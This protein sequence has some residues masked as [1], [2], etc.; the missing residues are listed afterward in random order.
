MAVSK[1][2][3]KKLSEYTIAD[4]KDFFYELKEIS[5]KVILI[6]I[7]NEFFNIALAK[8]KNG[9]LLIKKYIGNLYQK[10]Q[11]KNLCQQIHRLDLLFWVFKRVKIKPTEVAISIPS[12]ACYTR[13]IEIPD[14]VDKKDSIEF[15]ENQTLGY[16]YLSH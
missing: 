3:N 13:L 16:K 9:K 2:N 15:L 5:S 6:E 4:L 12:D 7:G 1:T 8:S 11:L 10:R 14:N